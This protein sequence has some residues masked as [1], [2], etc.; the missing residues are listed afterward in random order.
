MKTKKQALIFAALLI[1]LATAF[2]SCTR[3]SEHSA[4]DGGNLKELKNTAHNED[5]SSTPNVSADTTG[6]HRRENK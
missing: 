5:T 6:I 3:D 1:G 4:T 2:G